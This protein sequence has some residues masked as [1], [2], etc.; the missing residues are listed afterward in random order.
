MAKH[1]TLRHSGK[2]L[3]CENHHPSLLAALE[4]H[5]IPIDYQCRAGFCGVCRTRL[6]SGDVT[7]LTQPIALIQPDEILPCCCQPQNNIEIDL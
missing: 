3:T 7:W 2:Q 6:L 5:H 1:I 4:S